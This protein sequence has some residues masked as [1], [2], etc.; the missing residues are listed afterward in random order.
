MARH[1]AV[2]ASAG[3]TAIN[4]CVFAGLVLGDVATGHGVDPML[5]VAPM[6]AVAV[7]LGCVA[8][9]DD[10]RLPAAACVLGVASCVWVAALVCRIPRG[11]D[12]W[13][14]ALGAA[15]VVLEVVAAASLVVSACDADTTDPHGDTHGEPHGEP[16][17][18]AAER[19]ET[20]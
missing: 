11:D 10:E 7:W 15:N 6:A 14:D 16:L 5:V 2:T 20:P 3:V 12:A 9:V 4:T 17:L 13:L 1:N 8:V 18:T 19:E